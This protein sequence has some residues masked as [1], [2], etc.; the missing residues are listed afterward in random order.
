[1]EVIEKLISFV[2]PCYR[3][4]H[5]VEKVID[6]IIKTV[7]LRSEYN[8][9]IIC[10][11]DASPDNVLSVL[12]SVAE[13]NPKVKVVDLAKNKGKHA[14]ILAGHSF[15]SGEFIVDLDDDCQSPVCEFWRLLTPVENNECDVATAN[16]FKKKESFLKRMGSKINQ[17]MTNIMLDKPE[18]MVID[19]LSVMKR[20]VSDEMLKYKNPYPYF[21]GLVFSVTK[22][23]NV[24][25]ME[26]RERGDDQGSG[27]TLKKSFSLWLNGLTAFSVKPLRIASFAGACFAFIGFGAIVYILL[28]RLVFHTIYVLGYASLMAMLL[29]STGLIMLMLGMVGEYIGRVYISLNAAPQYTVK[30]TV[31]IESDS[32]K[33]R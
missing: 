15:A 33:N 29:F 27:Y 23:V 32:V 12:R 10:V 31:N 3:S 6:E 13:Q 21:E 9:E 28:G 5:T 26:Q 22:R 16:Y 2:I 4:E 1:M 17:L 11:N 18:G 8:Y 14:A 7:A 30:E 19:N 24:I 25:M 20:F